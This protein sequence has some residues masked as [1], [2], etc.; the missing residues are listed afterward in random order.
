MT[1]RHSTFEFRHSRPLIVECDRIACPMDFVEFSLAIVFLVIGALPLPVYPF[2]LLADVM[3]LAGER[4]G[5]D[6]LLLTVVSRSFQ[7]GSMAYPLVY[8]PCLVAAIRRLMGHDPHAAAI[9]SAIPLGL[10]ALLAILFC[11]WRACERE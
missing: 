11:A 5:K 9:I 3:S 2:V 8:V 6:P 4:S 7:L 1:V 10:L